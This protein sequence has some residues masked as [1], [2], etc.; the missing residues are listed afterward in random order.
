MTFEKLMSS[1]E[2]AAVLGLKPQTL[3]AWTFYRKIPFVKVGGRL[4]FEP[5]VVRELIERGR[6]EVGV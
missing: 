6:S 1:R 2:V 5:S 3:R 4:R